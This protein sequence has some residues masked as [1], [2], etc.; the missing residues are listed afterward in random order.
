MGRQGFGGLLSDE[1]WAHFLKAGNTRRH[2]AGTTII[3]QG[4]QDSAVFLLVEG[5]VKVSTVRADGTRTLL[6]LRGPGES[7]GE[8]SALSGLPRTATVAASGGDCLTRVL[9]SA[10]FRILAQDMGLES[11]LWKHTV[12][13][14]SESESLRAELTALPARQRLAAAL[15]RLA[16][17]SGADI[18]GAHTAGPAGN[19]HGVMLKLGLSQKELGD[20]IG[21]SRTSVST[22][23]T[24]LRSLGVIR[25]GRQY[26]AVLDVG[27]LRRLADGEE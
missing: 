17:L 3:H 26:I 13:R 1:Q 6:A 10:Q 16:S 2:Q 27:R 9:S 5:T 21:L 25:T 15:L 12:A 11:A 23:F 8:L 20:S 4:D 19:G 14:Q 18:E 22:E 7:L 24:R